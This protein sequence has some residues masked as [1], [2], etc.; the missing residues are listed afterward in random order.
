MREAKQETKREC[1]CNYELK[2]ENAEL[3]RI[4]AE[5]RK[6][7]DEAIAHKVDLALALIEAGME[8]R[9]IEILGH[10]YVISLKCSNNMELTDKDK[11]Y[12]AKVLANK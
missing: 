8:K 10:G 5:L 12:I 2:K 1:E 6:D 9:A 3:C 4:K 11:A 7:L